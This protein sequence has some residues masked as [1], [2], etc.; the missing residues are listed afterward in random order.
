MPGYIKKKLQEYKHVMTS[1]IQTTP[2]TPAPKQFG[3]E[4]QRPLPPDASPFLD[5]KGIKRVQQIV[6]SI[7]YYAHAV[8]MTV[9]MAL[10][11]I[12]IEQ[13]KATERTMTRC[14]QLLDYLAHHSEAKVRFYAS[15]MIMNIH[16]DASYLSEGRARSC[17]CGH[18]F[19]GWLPR[20]DEPIRING[21][22]HVSTDII[23][24]VVASAAEAELGAL[25]HNC[26]TGIIFR[27][28]LE[29][30]GHPQP[31]TPVHCDNATAVGIA[32]DTVKRQRSRSMEMRFFWIS[33]NCAQDMYTLHWHPGQENLADYQS[34]HHTGAHHT[35]VR[36][37]YLHESNSP[38]KLSRALKP[39]ALKGCVGTQ[40][41]GY[42]RK[43]PLP[44]IPLQ[45]STALTSYAA[46]LGNH[47]TSYLRVSRIPTW[48]DLARS[49]LGALR[50]SILPIAPRWLM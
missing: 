19:M 46:P 10:S 9:L 17:T 47:D 4:S 42:L 39:S 6:G 2:Y 27:K 20:D 14:T 33:D 16:S 15:D 11:S 45:Q 36:P 21:A 35:K 24:F 44:R 8:D 34:K 3:S 22:F 43:V 5:K 41:G 37:W 18:F 49:H 25:F 12:A 30:M 26:Q 50:S 1:K 7:L 28:I 40:D 31:K 38:R 48:S 29:D 23:C 13:T 32:K